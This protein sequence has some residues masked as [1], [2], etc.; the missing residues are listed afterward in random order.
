M[1][2][3]NAPRGV[4]TARPHQSRERFGPTLARRLSTAVGRGSCPTKTLGTCCRCVSVACCHR[5]DENDD[6]EVVTTR[7]T[8]KVVTGKHSQRVA[9]AQ[10]SHAAR[11]RKRP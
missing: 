9:E 4:L 8:H 3:G 1:A 10:A 6:I 7:V 2:E 5:P 11:A